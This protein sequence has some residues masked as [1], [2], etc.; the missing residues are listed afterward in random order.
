MANVF[1]NKTAANVSVSNTTIYQV[2]DATKSV[3]LGL[4][5]SNKGTNTIKATVY[6]D[7]ETNEAKVVGG[8]GVIE[9]NSNTTLLNGV[10]IPQNSTL[11]V[12]SGQK[13][14]LQQQDKIILKSDTS[15]SLDA[16]LSFM[17][18]T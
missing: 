3:I 16:V 13:L 7:S 9:V 1:K 18:I 14:N 11:E 2:A 10:S 5:L 15:D 12:F 6:L 4:V 17:E 8:S